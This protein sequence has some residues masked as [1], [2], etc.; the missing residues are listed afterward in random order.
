MKRRGAHHQ[1]AVLPLESYVVADGRRVPLGP[2]GDLLF[3]SG[4]L[5]VDEDA[6]DSV[7]L[8]TRRIFE[9]TARVL[10]K[11]GASLSDIVKTTAFLADYDGFNPARI[12][13]FMDAKSGAQNRANGGES[14]RRT[15][16]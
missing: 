10:R 6:R 7:E 15:I 8:L 13:I 9:R 3:L 2:S 1:D 4:S 12:E 16:V 14:V 5:C 11:L